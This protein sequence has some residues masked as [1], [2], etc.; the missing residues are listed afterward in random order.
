MLP[1]EKKVEIDRLR[2][3]TCAKVEGFAD[4]SESESKP[5]SLQEFIKNLQPISVGV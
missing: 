2:L 5:S 1:N 3:K 4:R